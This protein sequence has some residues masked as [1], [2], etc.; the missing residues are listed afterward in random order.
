[1]V[2]YTK[3]NYGKTLVK[4]TKYITDKVGENLIIR[5]H[6]KT[7]KFD[8]NDTKM[9][10]FWFIHEMKQAVELGYTIKKH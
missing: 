4:Y 3:T 1:M 8:G 6:T 7:I 2:V 10:V 9:N 5:I